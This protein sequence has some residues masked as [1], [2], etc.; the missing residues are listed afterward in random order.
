MIA[1]DIHTLLSVRLFVSFRIFGTD[2]RHRDIRHPDQMTV[3]RTYVLLP[4]PGPE[5]EMERSEL[6]PLA[7]IVRIETP[8]APT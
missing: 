6:L 2:G 8:I 1:Q 7:H 3:M 5:G 4:I